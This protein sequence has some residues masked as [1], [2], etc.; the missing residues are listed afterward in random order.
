MSSKILI[1][2]DDPQNRDILKIRLEAA[3][4]QVFE[5][6]DGEEGLRAVEKEAFDLILLDIM[7]PHRDGWQV[8]RALKSN[9]KTRSIPVI[10]LTART[11]PI[12]ELQSWECGADDYASKPLDAPALMK[13]IENL[14]ARRKA[15]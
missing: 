9:A 14:I 5:A 1:V 12:D 3:G 10:I 13:K 8:C 4:Y 2:D 11:L 15:P 6:S 7:M